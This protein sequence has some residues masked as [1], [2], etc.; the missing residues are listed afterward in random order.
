M[1][2]NCSKKEKKILGGYELFV[3]ANTER[4]KHPA[5]LYWNE[6]RCTKRCALSRPVDFTVSLIFSYFFAFF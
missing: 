6:A 3:Q 2:L 5:S 4:W 1:N